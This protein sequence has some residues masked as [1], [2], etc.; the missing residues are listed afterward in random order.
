MRNDKGWH[1]SYFSPLLHSFCLVV[2]LV[3]A[4]TPYKR[5]AYTQG[6]GKYRAEEGKSLSQGPI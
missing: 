1:I 2:R 3:T 5:G 6:Q 4:F